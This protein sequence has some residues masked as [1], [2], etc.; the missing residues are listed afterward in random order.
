MRDLTDPELLGM[1]AQDR[2]EEAF[3]ALVDRHAGLV[4]AACRRGLGTEAVLAE[5]VSQAVFA[6]IPVGRAIDLKIAADKPG[7]RTGEKI[8]FTVTADSKEPWSGKVR[9]GVH[10]FP[11]RGVGGGAQDVRWSTWTNIATASP[12]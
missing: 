1:L 5:E 2:S 4:Y 11:G 12:A 7:C 9:F 8:A 10:D 3:R 6:F